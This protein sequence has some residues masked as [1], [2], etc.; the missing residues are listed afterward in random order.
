M[1]FGDSAAG[2]GAL[3]EVSGDGEIRSFLGKIQFR[4]VRFAASAPKWV[5]RAAEIE[6]TDDADASHWEWVPFDID[7]NVKSG[8]LDLDHDFSCLGTLHIT[9]DG[10]LA[11]TIEVAAGKVA[12]WTPKTE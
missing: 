8:V 5:I 6:V 12:R 2:E 7:M 10:D 1:I 4:I 9:A 3:V 11:H